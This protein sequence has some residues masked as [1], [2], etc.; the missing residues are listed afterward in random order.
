[1]AV[2]VRIPTP[3][4]KLTENKAE[5]EVEAASITELVEKL[6]SQFGGI[7]ERLCDEAGKLRRF[8]NVYVNEEDIRFQ[9]GEATALKDGDE[10]AIVPAIAGG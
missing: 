10:V 9:A 8:I 5:V 2:T 1:M 4:R 6:E 3:L 7:K